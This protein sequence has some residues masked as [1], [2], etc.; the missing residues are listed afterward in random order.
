MPACPPFRVVGGEDTCIRAACGAEKE[1]P[2]RI[3]P[4]HK[5]KAM[6]KKCAELFGLA[7]PRPL[8]PGREILSA[9]RSAPLLGAFSRPQVRLPKQGRDMT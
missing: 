6:A 3:K 2:I 4:T 8:V 7:P 5:N 9:A 1:G